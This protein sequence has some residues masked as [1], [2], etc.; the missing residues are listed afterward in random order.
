MFRKRRRPTPGFGIP[1]PYSPMEGEHADLQVPSLH[2]Y[3]AMMQVAAEDT[4]DD[5][6]LCRGFDPRTNKFIDYEEG[7]SDKPGIAVAKPFGARRAGLYRIAQIFPAFLP[8]Q[9]TPN[10]TP[11]SPSDV[12]WRVGQN[13][14]VAETTQGHPVDLDETVD[15]MTRS[16]TSEYVNW[17]MISPSGVPELYWGMLMENHPGRGECFDILLGQWCWEEYKYRF[18]CDAASSEYEVGIDW[19]Y[20][21]SDGGSIPEPDQYAQGWF[22]RMPAKYTTSGYVYVVVSLDCDSDDDCATSHDLP[23]VT[24]T[25]PCA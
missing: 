3:C 15:E 8:I 9:G 11:P 1:S 10:Y 7:N 12:P 17:M 18:D 22:K 4:L 16:D 21:V 24:G 25:D 13:P 6:V 5:Y 20:T 23:C 19:H 14:G 2:P